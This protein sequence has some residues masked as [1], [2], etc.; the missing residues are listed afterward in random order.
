MNQE[1][2]MLNELQKNHRKRESLIKQVGELTRKERSLVGWIAMLEGAAF[3]PGDSVI[4]VNN[5]QQNDIF[6]TVRYA[7]T[8]KKGQLWIYVTTYEGKKTRRLPRNL[9]RV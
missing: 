3:R 5:T 1:I 8:N 6:A 2:R 7:K 4:I 9:R